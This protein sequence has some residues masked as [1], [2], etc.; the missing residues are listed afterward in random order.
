M[1]V[2]IPHFEAPFKITAKGAVVAEQDSRDEIESCV[3]N[4]LVCAQGFRTDLPDFG[5]PDVQFD[6]LPIDT[7]AVKQAI[8]KY[9]PR[10]A[11]T[12][13][14]TGAPDNPSAQ[15]LHVDLHLS[16]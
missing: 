7:D 8:R 4:I 9:E 2:E 11:L 16:E 1:T 10:A 15:T 13:S 12:V 5:M 6:A 14:A 3:S